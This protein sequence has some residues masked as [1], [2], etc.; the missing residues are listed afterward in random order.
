MPFPTDAFRRQRA[1]LWNA[2]SFNEGGQP[3]IGPLVELMVRWKYTRKEGT[4]NK[5][6]ESKSDVENTLHEVFEKIQLSPQNITGYMQP[7]L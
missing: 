7:F 6:F 4:H 1:C 2:T 5:N 3:T